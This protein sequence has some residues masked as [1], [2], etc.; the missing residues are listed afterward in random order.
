[1]YFQGCQNITSEFKILIKWSVNK[2]A[3][4][5]LHSQKKGMPSS[6]SMILA[7]FYHSPTGFDK[8]QTNARNRR[9][10]H[11]SDNRTVWI[12]KDAIWGNR[13]CIADAHEIFGMLN[14]WSCWRFTILLCE[15]VL[16]EKYI[17]EQDTGL[18]E[19]RGGGFIFILFLQSQKN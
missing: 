1:M 12:I 2:T 17:R 6:H 7:R 16:T 10:V 11:G 18:R 13:R 8:S 14:I 4:L 3:F 15:W 19:A 5:H 9:F